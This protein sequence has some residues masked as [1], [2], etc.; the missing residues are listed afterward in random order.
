MNG[1]RKRDSSITG[2]DARV[3]CMKGRGRARKTKRTKRHHT[4]YTHTQRQEKERR[5]GIFGG[6][7]RK[8][9]WRDAERLAHHGH[10]SSCPR[11]YQG[12]P[13]TKNENGENK[14]SSYPVKECGCLQ[15]TFSST[16]CWSSVHRHLAM[17]R[18]QL[19]LRYQD[20]TKSG[21]PRAALTRRF[22]RFL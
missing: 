9:E 12:M 20:G 2:H 1:G 6:K 14:S 21:R 5:K 18:S 10:N 17:V 15:T 8:G 22:G 4:T 13:L 19:L 16:C 11:Q 7:G 3:R